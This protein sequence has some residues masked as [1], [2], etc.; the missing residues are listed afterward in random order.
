MAH[1][2]SPA[3]DGTFIFIFIICASFLSDLKCY[4]SVTCYMEI[5]FE[6]QRK[7]SNKKITRRKKVFQCF[8][9]F[10]LFGPTSTF[11][12]HNFLIHFKWFKVLWELHM[13]FYNSSWNF[14]SNTRICLGVWELTFVVFTSLFVSVWKSTFVMF[15]VLFVLVLEPLYFV[16]W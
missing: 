5:I 7:I 1:H 8:F 12:P 3:H 16:R 6:V 11:K 4:G 2:S 9:F 13:K 14:N 10:I 15:N